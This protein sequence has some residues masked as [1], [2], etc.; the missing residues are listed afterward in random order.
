MKPL[1]CTSSD[2]TPKQSFY[3]ST[4]RL[5]FKVGCGP[6]LGFYI[7][8]VGQGLIDNLQLPVHRRRRLGWGSDHCHLLLLEDAE[9]FRSV[10]ARSAGARGAA[11]VARGRAGCDS[12]GAWG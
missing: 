8:Q 1:F 11:G 4:F 12:R 7:L 3:L 2:P 9:G 6:D 10:A 5:M